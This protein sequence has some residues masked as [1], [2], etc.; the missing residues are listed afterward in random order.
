MAKKY[1][2]QHFLTSE[3][4][5]GDILDAA[6]LQKNDVV[7]EIGPGKGVLTQGLLKKVAKVIAIEKD[8]EL[9]PFL[10]EKFRTELDEKRLT[11]IEKDIL[12]VRTEDV[13][14]GAYKV[15]ANIPYYIT[16]A[17][18]EFFL[19]SDHQPE[20]IVFLTQKEVAH[21]IVA[22]DG[23][24]SILSMS[25]KVYG[26][27]K[28]VERVPARY[29]SPQPKVDSAILAIRDI[30]KRSFSEVCE[31]MYFKIL[32]A[33][34]RH[35]RKL[36]MNNLEMLYPKPVLESKFRSCSVPTD[37][38]AENLSVESWLCLAKNVSQ[39]T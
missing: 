12:S 27:P 30:S 20:R 14:Q 6:E 39:Q 9:I 25:I 36:L 2:G 37:S 17:L 33:G 35:K 4:I 5:V 19:T 8:A 38:R 28:Y 7:L 26:T 24:E 32:K 22:R 15:V 16:G 23:K 1:L 13:I 18:F 11:L 29:F 34:F 3:K 10:S 21:R 31:E